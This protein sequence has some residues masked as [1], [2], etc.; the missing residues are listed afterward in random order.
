M[1]PKYLLLIFLILF[2]YSII[3]LARPMIDN[4]IPFGWESLGIA[5]VFLLGYFVLRVIQH[6]NKDFRKRSL[7]IGI[8]CAVIFFV[9]FIT[10]TNNSDGPW[11]LFVSTMWILTIGGIIGLFIS[12]IIQWGIISFKKD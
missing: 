2:V 5:I 8:A 3:A 6:Q 1:Q 11:V 10:I 9:L 4:S 12:E 7:S